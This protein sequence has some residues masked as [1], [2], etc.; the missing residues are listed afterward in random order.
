MRAILPI[1]LVAFALVAA[2]AL[3]DPSSQ[4]AEATTRTGPGFAVIELF[5]SE[6]CSSCPPADDAV[7]RLSAEAQAKGLPVYALA[8]HVDYWDS[9]GWPDPFASRAHTLR[10][11]GYRHALRQR[12]LYTP[13]VIVNG[14]TSPRGRQAPVE[15]AVHRAI[16]RAP[17]VRVSGT[18]ER[19]GRHWTVSYAAEGPVDGRT[20]L[21]ALTE[22]GLSVAVP[23]GENGGRTLQH[24]HVVRAFTEVSGA[25]GVVKL[26]APPGLDPKAA[27]VVL[28]VQERGTGAIVGAGRATRTTG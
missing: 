10:Q 6:G 5:T 13:Q 22:S 8:W 11:E 21:V 20:V 25:T 18:V 14:R 1:I 16:A 26:V 4:S 15:Q 23:R 12:S 27:E 19:A 17:E 28:L 7:R 3:T 9:L 2:V 24:A